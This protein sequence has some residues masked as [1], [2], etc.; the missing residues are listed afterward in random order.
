M[1]DRTLDDAIPELC[2]SFPDVDCKPGE[3]MASYRVNGKPFVYY[4]RNHHG[5]GRIALWLNLAD[6][7]QE[8][9][10]NSGLRG[11]FF[12]PYVGTNGY[13]GVELDKDVDWAMVV[14]HVKEAFLNVGKNIDPKEIESIQVAAPNKA[15]D[16]KD[17]NP[18]LRDEVQVLLDK[19]R[20]F[21]T[22]L[23]EVSET[24]KFGNPAFLAGKKT[25][26]NI[27]AT[28]FEMWL[29]VWVGQER[30]MDLAELDTYVIP[31]YIGHKGWIRKYVNQS[32]EEAD[33]QATLLFSYRHFAL[34]RMLKQ[35][36]E[37]FDL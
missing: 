35:L 29:E 8:L 15:I 3:H 14:S 13:L 22:A 16:P 20:R 12:P 5:D 4:M 1:N 36:D 30:Q 11:Y 26:V 10:L 25:F 9:Y 17:L 19:V 18:C 28:K 32:T 24:T 6:G 2:F 31:N 21:C 37:N 34:K 23:P 7:A 27:G 33:I